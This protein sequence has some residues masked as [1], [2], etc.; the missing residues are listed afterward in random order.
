MTA[1]EKGLAH[2]MVGEPQIKG[3][4]YEGNTAN[5]NYF[6][7]YADGLRK[8]HLGRL[9]VQCTRD[10]TI[11]AAVVDNDSITCPTCARRYIREGSVYVSDRELK[12]L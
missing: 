11:F 8:K 2:A 9:I 7:G 4:A 6:L 10:S 1:Y 3:R 5:K 12:L